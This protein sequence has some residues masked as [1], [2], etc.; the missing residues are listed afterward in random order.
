MRTYS[1]TI[2]GTRRVHMEFQS[3][4]DLI[5]ELEMRLSQRE[6]DIG[7]VERLTAFRL[8]PVNDN[9]YKY[10]VAENK[11]RNITVMCHEFED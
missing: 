8:R 11:I 2:M 7:L 10:M 3:I 1:L 4:N 9:G 6:K 5:E